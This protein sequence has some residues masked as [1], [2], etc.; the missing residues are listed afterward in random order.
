MWRLVQLLRC[1]HTCNA[2]WIWISPA[3]ICFVWWIICNCFGENFIDQGIVVTFQLMQEYNRL[4]RTGSN[5]RCH[6]CVSL[7]YCVAIVTLSLE[8]S[9]HLRCTYSGLEVS[10][11]LELGGCVLI[12]IA[13]KPLERWEAATRLYYLLLLC[14]VAMSFLWNMLFVRFIRK[15]R[16]IQAHVKHA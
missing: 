13:D 2:M 12:L 6:I 8:M 10:F 1:W 16:E 14:L 9:F 5:H 7:L 3:L 11:F 15:E 4:S